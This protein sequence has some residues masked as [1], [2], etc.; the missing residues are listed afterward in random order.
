VTVNLTIQNLNQCCLTSISAVSDAIEL[1]SGVSETTLIFNLKPDNG[2]DCPAPTILLPVVHVLAVLSSF[3][4]PDCPVPA[5]LYWLSCHGYA[6]LSFPVLAFPSLLSCSVCP[7][8]FSVL[9]R[10]SC[11]D[12]PVPVFLSHL[13]CLQQCHHVL[14]CPLSCPGW[15][16]TTILDCCPFCPPL[17]ICSEWLFSSVLSLVSCLQFCCPS[18]HVPAV[19]S[20][21]SCPAVLSRRS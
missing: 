4:C 20:P 16:D 6:V 11:L 5:V 1:A 14:S 19:L 21:L 10:L 2:S 7:V 13:S 18:C 12:C 15:S 8:C 17:T 9:S 3:S